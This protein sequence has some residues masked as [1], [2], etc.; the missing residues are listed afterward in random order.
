MKRICP[1]I[2][3][4]TANA[5]VEY[6]HQCLASGMQDFLTKPVRTKELEK[7]ILNW[8]PKAKT[9]EEA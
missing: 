2:I 9:I 8:F 5:T 6:Q 7:M 1:L 4:L 3:A